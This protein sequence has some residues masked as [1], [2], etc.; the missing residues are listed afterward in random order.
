MNVKLRSKKS[1][2]L[3]VDDPSQLAINLCTFNN[4]IVPARSMINIMRQTNNSNFKKYPI[5]PLRG[6]TKTINGGWLLIK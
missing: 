4:I 2:L 3:E 5:Y 6:N 1:K